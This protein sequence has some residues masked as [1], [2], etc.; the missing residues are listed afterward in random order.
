MCSKRRITKIQFCGEFDKISFL[1]RFSTVGIWTHDPIIY[2]WKPL[3][4]Q[5]V[6]PGSLRLLTPRIPENLIISG[7]ILETISQEISVGLFLRN[8]RK[9]NGSIL[10]NFLEENLGERLYLKQFREDSREV[11]VSFLWSFQRYLN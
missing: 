9:G 1:R 4:I 7:V 8:I 10:D 5:S 6:R 3:N 11:I 2:I